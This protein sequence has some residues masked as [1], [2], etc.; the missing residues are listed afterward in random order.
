MNST[1]KLIGEDFEKSEVKN[2][3]RRSLPVVEEVKEDEF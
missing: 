1:R 3:F 2:S